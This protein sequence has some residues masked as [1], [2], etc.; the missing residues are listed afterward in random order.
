MASTSARVEWDMAA[1]QRVA[2]R[3]D[4]TRDALKEATDRIVSTANAMGSGTHS[5]GH[6]YKTKGTGRSRKG[7]GWLEHENSP[8]AVTGPAAEYAGNVRMFHE[9]YMGIVYTANYSAQ[10]DNH[11]NNTLLK[12]RG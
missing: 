4:E 8:A 12:A 10:L 2:A 9:G 5:G 11:R 1:L 3:S 7:Q 6:G